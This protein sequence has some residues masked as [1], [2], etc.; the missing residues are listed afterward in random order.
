MSGV[1]VAAVFFIV[2]WLVFFAVLPFGARSQVDEG[3]V[4]LGTEHGAPAR[5]D[6]GRKAAITTVIAAMVTGAVYLTFRIFGL[7][8]EDLIV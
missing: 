4:T 1:S 3:D 5:P 2:W 7:S 8:L 6:L